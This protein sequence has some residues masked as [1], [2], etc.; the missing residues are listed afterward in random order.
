MVSQE[1][2][3]LTKTIHTVPHPKGGLM[4]LIRKLRLLLASYSRL[5]GTLPDTNP[6]I[7]NPAAGKSSSLRRRAHASKAY[8]PR[9]SWDR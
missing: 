9:R 3:L 1:P 4:T 6:P 2:W 8:I 7:Y 5:W